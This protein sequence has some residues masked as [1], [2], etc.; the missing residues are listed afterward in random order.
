MPSKTKQQVKQEKRLRSAQ[1]QAKRNKAELKAMPG[2]SNKKENKGNLKSSLFEKIFGSKT[3][4]KT[5]QESIPYKEMRRDGICRVENRI[6]SKC[7]AFQDINY[8]LAQNDDKTQIFE[9][10]CDFINYYDSTIHVQF[11]FINQFGNMQEIQK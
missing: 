6:Y 11:S 1:K 3:A 7:I 2:K 5:V 10:Y 4:P 8:Q 9:S